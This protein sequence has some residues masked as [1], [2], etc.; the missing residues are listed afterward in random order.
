MTWGGLLLI[1]FIGAFY[2]YH[3]PS[4]TGENELRTVEGRLFKTPQYEDR[5]ENPNYISIQLIED[6]RKYHVGGCGLRVVDRE[7]LY[8]LNSND[9]INLVVENENYTKKISFFNKNV[10]VLE[11]RLPDDSEL[12]TL[13]QVNN[14]EKVEWKRVLWLSPFVGIVLVFSIVAAVRKTWQTRNRKVKDLRQS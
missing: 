6:K 4:V 1:C 14:C 2:L 3:N 11:I 12:L 10:N 13:S 8:S 7:A 9:R 5:G